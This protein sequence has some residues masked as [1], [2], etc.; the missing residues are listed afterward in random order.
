MSSEGT[1]EKDARKVRKE[2]ANEWENTR[3]QVGKKI[4]LAIE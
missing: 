4:M 3:G 2:K 1:N